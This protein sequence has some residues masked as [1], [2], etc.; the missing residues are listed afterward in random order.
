MAGHRNIVEMTVAGR[1]AVI[2]GGSSGI[3]RAV[4]EALVA[5]GAHV[6]LVGQNPSRLKAAVDGASACA[7]APAEVLPLALDVRRE[8][9]MQRMADETMRR[10]GRIDLL[11]AAAGVTRDPRS[12]HLMPY[13]VA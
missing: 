4:A 13:P 6:T 10:F 7:K 2:T 12:N 9:D 1:V 8:A 5:N 11:V 3:G